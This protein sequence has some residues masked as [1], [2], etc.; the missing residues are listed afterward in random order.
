LSVPVDPILYALCMV[1][2]FLPS[3]ISMPILVPPEYWGLG[4]FIA[5]WGFIAL[6]LY[7]LWF[8]P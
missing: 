3:L 2:A 6:G 1:I 8:L 7:K 4:P 5:Y